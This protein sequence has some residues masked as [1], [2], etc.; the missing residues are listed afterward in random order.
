MADAEKGERAVKVEVTVREG[1]GA[2]E[3]R[4]SSAVLAAV[5]VGALIV[6]ALVGVALAAAWGDSSPPAAAA[7][8]P[9]REDPLPTPLAEMTPTPSPTPEPFPTATAAP[10]PPPTPTVDPQ[11]PCGGGPERCIQ[12]IGVSRRDRVVDLDW[13][14]V[15]FEPT[16]AGGFHAHFF[17]DTYEAR[18][19]GNNA[20]NF[21]GTNGMWWA[22]D[23]Q[24]FVFD[25]GVMPR[26][27]QR[28]CVTVG[29]PT[30]GVDNPELFD[31]V[32]IPE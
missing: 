9:Q 3:R 31:C 13:V 25:P 10:T 4:W 26:D 19:A 18:Q 11:G 21:G 24:P 15:G 12:I 30:H 2:I 22:V 23:A 17:W 6:G 14:A 16:T 27:A 29:T 1:A 7:S 32:E 8:E 20:A 5:A 28:L